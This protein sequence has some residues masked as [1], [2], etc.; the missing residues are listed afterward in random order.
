[1]GDLSDVILLVF[2]FCRDTAYPIT[3]FGHLWQFT[4]LDIL[5]MPVIAGITIKI[6]TYI[7]D[8][9]S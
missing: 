5:L 9:V 1:M 4:I 8:L 7:I 3:L 6:V 2:N